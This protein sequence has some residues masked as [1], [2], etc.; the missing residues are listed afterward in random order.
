MH[1]SISIIVKIVCLF[2][3]V[4]FIFGCDS[5]TESQQAPQ[6]IT[7]KIAAAPQAKPSTLP[8]SP[9]PAQ[10][11]TPDPGSAAQPTPV[12][13]APELQKTEATAQKVI[14]VPPSK[15]TET[16]SVSTIESSA[17]SEKSSVESS[18]HATAQEADKSQQQIALEVKKSESEEAAESDDE[19]QPEAGLTKMVAEAT[20]GYNPAGKIDPFMP[21]FEEK[22]VVPT[23]TEEADKQKKKRRIPLTPLE[24]VDLSQLKLVGIV[25]A[26][27]GN[28]ALVEEASGKG[29]IIKKGTFIGIHDGRVI[30]ILKD[31]V[32]VEEEVEN[33]LGQVTVEKKELKLQKPP[34]EL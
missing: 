18:T 26:P 16:K 7:Q 17:K 27:T 28:K 25:Q 30:E 3:F 31:R 15:P 23:E 9:A 32:V 21:L 33:V 1:K 22:P 13:P 5:Q 19:A 14:T 10:T 2:F 20:D 8:A 12:Q 6:V 11:K 34:G 29:Y 24:R 4:I